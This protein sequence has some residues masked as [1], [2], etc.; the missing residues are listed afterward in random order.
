MLL[1]TMMTATTIRRV[2]SVVSYRARVAD[3]RW[4]LTSF[5]RRSF[6]SQQPRHWST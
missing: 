1:V 4:M 5:V 6:W 3:R 2:L